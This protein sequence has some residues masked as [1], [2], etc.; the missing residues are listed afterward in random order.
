M[1]GATLG[2]R[3]R[4]RDVS[5]APAALNLLESTAPADREQGAALLRE[6]SPPRSAARLPGT[7]SG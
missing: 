4:E 3:L 2:A 7:S 6:V 1:T 5:V